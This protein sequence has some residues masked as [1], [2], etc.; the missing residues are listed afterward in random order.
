MPRPST[1]RTARL[2]IGALSVTAVTA[3]S[4]AS[5][6]QEPPPAPPPEPAAPAT[7]APPPPAAPP[8]V[9]QPAPPPLPPPPPVMVKTEQEIPV[10][11]FDVEA[12][13]FA[14]GYS[15][16]SQVPLGLEANPNTGQVQATDLTVP[17]L[18]LRY[19]MNPTMGLDVAVGLWWTGG[20]TESAGNKTDKDGEFGVLIQG[21]LPLALA[22]YRHVSFQ[23]VPYA[24]FAHGQTKLTQPT[25]PGGPINNAD[26]SGTRV[27]V[28]ART[29]FELFF[30]FMGVP[31]LALS[32]TVG[33]RFEYR[34]YSATSGGL[35]DSDTTMG[36]STTVQNNPWDIFTGNVAAR[37]YF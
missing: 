10:S 6:A 34:K 17:A 21:G 20:S 32:A 19:W 9:V 22:T 24:A 37:Y 35:T 27:E 16:L 4:A 23:V 13:R 8:P 2:L 1:C 5:Q 3:W 29:G 12:R 36:F 31:E 33:L 11:D 14:I 18:G 25:F 30:G 28:G 7:G 15:G 26:I